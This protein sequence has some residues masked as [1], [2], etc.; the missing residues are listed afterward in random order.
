MEVDRM[1]PS[2]QN[3]LS[4][5]GLEWKTK[6]VMAGLIEDIDVRWWLSYTREGN[7]PAV[8]IA[9]FDSLLLLRALAERY[10]AR[11]MF[12]VLKFDSSLLVR[13]RLAQSMLESIPIL[14]TT[15]DFVK[16]TGGDKNDDLEL[17]EEDPSK[18][19]KEK[20]NKDSN[21]LD[22]VIKGLRKE[23]GKSV[24]FRECVISVLSDPSLDA[25]I[26]WCLIK[27]CEN[28][29]KPDPEPI[30]PKI[31]V[32][33]PV[34]IAQPQRDASPVLPPPVT[35]SIP[36]LK[37]SLPSH[38]TPSIMDSPLPF[39]TPIKAPTVPPLQPK[40]AIKIKLGKMKPNAK[41][42][43]SQASGMTFEEATTCQ[44]IVKR[45]LASKHSEIF[46]QPVD[47]MRDGA[48]N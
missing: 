4:V 33:I 25:S 32:R 46:R 8:R 23:I 22:R 19:K 40:P 29:Y 17:L 34:P 18:P 13:R 45:L 21:E 27:I 5:A 43:P 26:R 24:M 2:Y 1:V 44:S 3:V 6:I 36:K 48:P 39:D 20:S 15:E 28:L 7:F 47:P 31:K 14:I 11:Y 41:L 30:L 12:A 37:L 10:I 35:P 9:A 42:L 16:T 38:F